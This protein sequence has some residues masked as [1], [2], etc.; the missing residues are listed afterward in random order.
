MCCNKM[1][2]INQTVNLF[3]LSLIFFLL[4]YNLIETAGNFLLN[5]FSSNFIA[6]RLWQK[7]DTPAIIIK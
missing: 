2:L 3:K 6:F 4:T 5:E 7:V 1:R